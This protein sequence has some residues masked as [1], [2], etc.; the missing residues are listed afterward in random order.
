LIKSVLIAIS[1][2][3]LVQRIDGINGLI[4][5]GVSVYSLGGDLESK[6]LA[7]AAGLKFDLAG[8]VFNLPG[9]V[10]ISPSGIK[11]KPNILKFHIQI[12]PK[13]SPRFIN[14]DRIGIER[15]DIRTIDV[16]GVR[17]IEEIIDTQFERRMF[18]DIDMAINV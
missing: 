3:Y 10:F 15:I 18:I 2:P 6:A 7:L 4:N 1:S 8:F 11:I 5:W 9:L 13:C 16:V 12:E 14:L 17:S